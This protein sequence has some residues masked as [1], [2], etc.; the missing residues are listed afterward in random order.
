M[1]DPDEMTG[2]DDHGAID[3]DGF[4]TIDSD[5]FETI[6]PSEFDT[7]DPDGTID[8][9]DGVAPYVPP[10]SAES[11]PA[12]ESSDPFETWEE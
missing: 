8:P 1:N 11:K 4:D 9:A 10:G 3:S 7:I 6:D 2:G 5:T 12:S